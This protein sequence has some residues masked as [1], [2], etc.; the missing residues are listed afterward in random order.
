MSINDNL[1]EQDESSVITKRF[2]C[3][4]GN[5][6]VS[7]LIISYNQKDFVEDALRSAIDQD[8]ENLEVVI[9]DDGSTDGTADI[10]AEWQRR[11]PTR[12]VALL[13]KENVGI[14]RNSNCGLQACT[15]DF[16]AFQG[17]D[18]ILLPGKIT[19]QIQWF[20][21]D[22]ERV[23]CGHQVEVFYEDGLRTPHL[24]ESSLKEGRGPVNLIRNGVPF[25]A[26]AIMLRATSIPPHGFDE[27]IPVASDWLL[28]IEALM[29]SGKY[30]YV[31]GVYAR[32]R[33][34]DRSVS[35]KRFEMLGDVERTLQTVGTRYPV[36]KKICTDSMIRH[37]IYFGGV[38]HLN[39]G[40]KRAARENF[41]STIRK[42]PLYPKAWIRL[43]Q[44][45]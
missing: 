37:V 2:E 45:F 35:L 40:N 7:I 39:A 36:Y 13:N 4:E 21:E 23:L 3:K 19:A 1:S 41:I 18:D 6:K 32:Y 34:H 38:R 42:K 26:T 28:W 30:G 44:T 11:H 33:R 31:T 20:L 5:P 27:S 10:I 14:T 17:G 9:S 15:G 12:L 22:Q 8:Y 29:P 16:I 25:A 24:A 43:L